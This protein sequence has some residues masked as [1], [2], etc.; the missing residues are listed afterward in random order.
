[1][2]MKRVAPLF[3]LALATGCP[4]GPPGPGGPWTSVSTG[5]REALLSVAGTSATDVWAVG[6]DKGQ[7]P[8]VLH[9]D[10]TTWTRRP[11]GQ[12]GHLW[13]V[14]PFADGTAIM[15]GGSTTLLRWNGAA[16][17]RMAT[18]GV[19]SH[20]IFGVWGA[21]PDDVYAV[22]SVSS[23]NGFIWHYDGAAWREVAVPDDL[24]EYPT[25]DVPGFFKVW[26]DGHGTVFVCGGSGVLLVS[27]DGAPFEV[28]P[29]GTE[30]SLFTVTGQGDRVVAVGGGTQAIL[31]E[32]ELGSPLTMRAVNGPAILQGVALDMEGHGYAVGEGGDVFARDGDDW[33]RISTGLDLDIQSL[34][35]VWIDPEG[36]VWAAGGNVLGSALDA[37]AL[38]HAGPTTVPAYTQEPGPGPEAETCPAAAVDLAPDRSIARRWNEQLMNAIRRDIPR[39]TVHARNLFHASA[40]MWDAWA[41][42][43]ADADGY[44]VAEKQTAGDVA[45]ARREAISYATYR[46]LAH[47]YDPSLAVGGKVTLDCMKKFMGVLG[48]DPDDTTVT[49]DTARAL[50][51]RIGAAIIAATVDDGANEAN[52]YADTTGYTSSNPPLV[53]DSPGVRVD[54]PS[55]WQE[56]LLAEA[57]TQNGIPVDAGVQGYIGAHWT[58]VTPFAMTRSAPGAL[59]HDPGEG[60]VW[61]EALRGHAV[62]VLLKHTKLDPALEETIDIGP[63][64]YGNN[65]LGANDGTG[66][67]MN[68]VTG[69]PYAPNVVKLG[70]FSRVLAEFWAD[71]PKSETPPG[72]WNVLANT[73]ADAPG[74]ER[75]L[76]GQGEAL[77][78][79]EWDVKVYLALNG[80][81]HDAAITAWELKRHF[82][83]ARPITL[84]RHMAMLGQSSDPQGPSYDP[85]GLPLVP[86]AIE[87][88]TE[89]SSAPGQRHAHLRRFIGEVAVRSWRGEP[90]DRDREVGGVAWIRARRWI[91][92]QRRNFVTPAFPGFV[93]G[94]S[95]FSRSAAE[96]LTQLT[97]SPYFPGGLGEFVAE[98]DTYLVFE[99]GPSEDIH[100]Q[101][102]TYYDAADQAGQS[103]L[104]GGIHVQ[105]DDFVGRTFGSDVGADAVTRARA[106]FD[107]TAR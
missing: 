32:G 47:R 82:L 9:F 99:A 94:H 29:T 66:H 51:N 105:P 43:D 25:K 21:A 107:G 50:G 78:A 49:G 88:V 37:G 90:G 96:V 10:G 56:L 65:S 64:A 23:R 34:H 89:A 93:S 7:G 52:K 104:W 67:P 1:M 76:L 35:A 61:G 2:F 102:A 106:F 84:I 48:Y 71:G 103:R 22:G 8:I 100:L 33:V 57:E 95:T 11:T 42:Y 87:L 13:W 46:V 85:E 16:F 18:P 45:A 55:V 3:A 44:F 72:H 12:R 58:A 74:F 73:V 17:E 86:D 36:G 70:D 14:Q 38:V 59:Y 62:E 24:P 19:A 68:P 5:L 26:G 30:L 83:S 31:L 41:A 20:T 101:W 75:K 97:G 77:D 15:G 69:Q 81:V 91:P 4:D 54:D 79:L 40:A 92:Y 60:P 63:G 39:P 28:L 98:K 27:R 6:A 53:V 80:A